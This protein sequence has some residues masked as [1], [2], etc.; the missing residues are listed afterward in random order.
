V[1]SLPK[2]FLLRTSIAQGQ[3][4]VTALLPFFFSPIQLNKNEKATKAVQ[5]RAAL[6]T[7]L[8]YSQTQAG[9]ST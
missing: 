9:T 1:A 7:P 4:C 6:N 2:P 5:K 3:W 8:H